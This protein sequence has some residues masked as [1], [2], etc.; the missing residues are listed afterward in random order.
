MPA[1]N[2][3]TSPWQTVEDIPRGTPWRRLGQIANK[4][5][6]RLRASGMK[7]SQET[8]S[9]SGGPSGAWFRRMCNSG[10]PMA[11]PFVEGLERALGWPSGHAIKILN[12]GVDDAPLPS[13]AD[14][15]VL[16]FDP[17]VLPDDP[18]LREDVKLAAYRAGLARARELKSA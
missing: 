12:G 8:L 4:R 7:I 2:H 1:R 14:E 10:Q 3:P 16:T 9:I 6:T 13:R 18:R 15:L 5:M 11:A 17:G